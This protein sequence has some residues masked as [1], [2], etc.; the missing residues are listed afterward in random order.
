MKGTI[1][2]NP[3]LVNF[4]K[5]IYLAF[6]FLG[7]CIMLGSVYGAFML[8]NDPAKGDLGYAILIFPAFGLFAGLIFAYQGFSI[9]KMKP[10]DIS[11]ETDLK[12]DK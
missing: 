8:I 11:L 7:M 3:R 6:G 10:E 1:K 12:E 2:L 9:W 4:A 5:P